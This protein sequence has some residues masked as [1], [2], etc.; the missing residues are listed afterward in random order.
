MHPSRKTAKLYYFRV[1]VV[2]SR[3]VQKILRNPLPRSAF[4]G[5]IYCEHPQGFHI[6]PPTFGKAAQSRAQARLLHFRSAE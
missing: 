2:K 1:E 3:K 4:F 5:K 6:V